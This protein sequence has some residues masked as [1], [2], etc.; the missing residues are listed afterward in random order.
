MTLMSIVKSREG[1]Y[2]ARF[3]LGIAEVYHSAPLPTHACH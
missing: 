1:L 2:A 3:C